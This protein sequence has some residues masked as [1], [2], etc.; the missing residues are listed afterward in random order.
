MSADT[1]TVKVNALK[2]LAKMVEPGGTDQPVVVE[3][4]GLLI[5]SI[6]ASNQIIIRIRM[7]IPGLEAKNIP[8]KS[9]H[10]GVSFTTLTNML[11]AGDTVEIKLASWWEIT[12]ADFRCKMPTLSLESVCRTPKKPLVPDPG[13]YPVS[14]QRF[15]DGVSQ[16]KKAIGGK[17]ATS[18]FTIT[19]DPAEPMR[20]RLSDEDSSLGSM[21]LALATTATAAT[22]IEQ[23]FAYEAMLPVLNAIRLFTESVNIRFME[24]PGKDGTAAHDT[25]GPD[26]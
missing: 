20:A 23:L 25:R 10:V 3:D 2:A 14:V 4:G 7:A 21:N 12:S 5:N 8:E 1:I 19:F 17:D 16:L 15:Y 24:M 9:R 6:E 26:N 11:P 13:E 22:K 18:F